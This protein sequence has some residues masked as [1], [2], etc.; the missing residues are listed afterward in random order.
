MILTSGIS[1]ELN[2]DIAAAYVNGLGEH[3]ALKTANDAT[4]IF[5]TACNPNDLRK[6]LLNGIDGFVMAAG[7][8]DRSLLIVKLIIPAATDFTGALFEHLLPRYGGPA[9]VYRPNVLFV[10]EHL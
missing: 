6:N 9:A 7:G 3:P 8:D 2:S 10:A 1:R 4:R 5:L